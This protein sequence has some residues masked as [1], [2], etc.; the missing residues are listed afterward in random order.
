MAK[1]M[2][3]SV[4]GSR[5]AV[6]VDYENVY[7]HDKKQYGP[8]GLRSLAA[9]LHAVAAQCG[10]VT[11][12]E[13]VA[14]FAEIPGAADAF[15]EAG[16]EP[17]LSR[18][19]GI[20]DAADLTVVLRLMDPGKL[21]LVGVVFLVSGDRFMLNAVRKAQERGLLVVV[22]ACEGALSGRLRL[23]AD[24][25]LS[26]REIQ[27]EAARLR[28]KEPGT[29]G[30]AEW[31]AAARSSWAAA[32]T[33][34]TAGRPPGPDPAAVE[35]ASVR[36]PATPTPTAPVPAPTPAR[37]VFTSPSALKLYLQCPQRYYRVHVEGLPDKQN[38][39]GFTG[40]VVHETLR[41]FF[42]LE[43]AARTWEAMEAA[44][45]K[46]WAAS[47]ERRKVFGSQE[48]ERM[49]GLEVLV[50]LKEFFRLAD[51][52][53]RPFACEVFLKTELAEGLTLRGKVDRIDGKPGEAFTVVDYKTGKLPTQ[54]P[55]LT[56]DF[57]L[58]LYCAMVGEAYGLPVAKVVL[59]YLK[60]HRTYEY[61][62][63]P[64]D[65][66]RARSRARDIAGRIAADETFAPKPSPLCR[67][68]GFLERCSA[69]AEAEAKLAGKAQPDEPVA[70]PF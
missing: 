67:Y 8:G 61:S 15:H 35:P 68:C 31:A 12:A 40:T 49:A 44:L 34:A 3:P 16:Y 25:T 43:P 18:G 20:P 48:E 32:A 64:V 29:L 7:Y 47:L 45:R 63:R 27:A 58:P 42:G 53:V 6:F 33:Q 28:R 65:V 30:L 17:V 23:T 41:G 57:Q 1:A 50:E 46:A 4:S 66:E 60:E 21:A 54:A 13:A 36:A 69:R 39:A 55:T 22:V 51:R 56:D 37:H 14:P 62:P 5:V 70:L 11:A 19:G 26:I 24:K 38:V 52:K 59:L 9:D 2:P 10:P